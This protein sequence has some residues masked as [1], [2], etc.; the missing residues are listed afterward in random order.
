MDYSTHCESVSCFLVTKNPDG[1]KTT[2]TETN[3]KLSGISVKSSS[4]M[5]QVR[6]LIQ[7]TENTSATQSR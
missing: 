4:V 3:G 1:L 6:F 7:N 2:L 5:C